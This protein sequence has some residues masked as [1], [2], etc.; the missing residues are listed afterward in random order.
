M[1]NKPLTADVLV[2]ITE[3]YAP[4][5]AACVQRGLNAKDAVDTAFEVMEEFRKRVYLE[6]AKS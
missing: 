2:K 1:S 6:D 4:V 5:L 3:L